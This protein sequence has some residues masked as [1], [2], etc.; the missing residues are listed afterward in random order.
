MV[1]G[2][3]RQ[4][5][6]REKGQLGVSSKPSTHQFDLHHDHDSNECYHDWVKYKSSRCLSDQPSQKGDDGSPAGAHAANK[7]DSEYLEIARQKTSKHSLSAWVYW[8]DE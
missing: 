7:A 5:G 4:D 2:C 8:S 1:S 6:I 3:L